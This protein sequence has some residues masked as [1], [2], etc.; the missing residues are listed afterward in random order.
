M[1][2]FVTKLPSS[3]S[4]ASRLTLTLTHPPRPPG[5]KKKKK[6]PT[7]EQ[8]GGRAPKRGGLS[9]EIGLMVVQRLGL[10]ASG[11][12]QQRNGSGMVVALFWLLVGA[13]PVD[14]IGAALVGS[15][16]RVY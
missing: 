8:H 14:S 16:S 7:P 1:L 13:G 15:S 4:H 5:R 9:L 10:M 12:G 11:G 2:N 6:T 3:E